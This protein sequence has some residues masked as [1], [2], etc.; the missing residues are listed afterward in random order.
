MKLLGLT[1]LVASASAAEA[2]A[3]TAIV[4]AGCN[5][6][7]KKAPDGCVDT[8]GRCARPVNDAALAKY[9]VKTDKSKADAEKIYADATAEEKKKMDEEK[10]KREDKCA[11]DGDCDGDTYDWSAGRCV[12]VASCGAALTEA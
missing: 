5:P 2:V 9:K 8:V 11:A 6:N 7:G 1:L 12:A 3:G 4:G 10:K